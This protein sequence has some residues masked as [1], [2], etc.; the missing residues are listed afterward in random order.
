MDK[1]ERGHMRLTIESAI[2]YE[3][4]DYFGK[5]DCFCKL[6]FNHEGE[7]IDE[8]KTKTHQESGKKPIWN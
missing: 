7:E 8:Y 4:Q 5:M 6:V 1:G 3:D 2:L